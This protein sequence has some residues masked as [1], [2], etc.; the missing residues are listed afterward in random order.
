M[1]L[2]WYNEELD[3]ETNIHQEAEYIYI[4]RKDITS[5]SILFWHFV[6]RN[7]HA[8]ISQKHKYLSKSNYG[9][10]SNGTCQVGQVCCGMDLPDITNDLPL[11]IGQVLT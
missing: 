3:N 9:V 8:K 1:Q 6:Y 4:Y 7:V 2:I 10:R 11:A 5:F